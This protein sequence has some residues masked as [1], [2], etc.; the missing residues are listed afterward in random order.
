MLDLLDVLDLVAVFGQPI[1]YTGQGSLGDSEYVPCASMVE[2]Q[3][4]EACVLEDDVQ[5]HEMPA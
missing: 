3:I 4:L 1:C 5:G 2:K